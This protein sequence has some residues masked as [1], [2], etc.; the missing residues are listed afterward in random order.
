LSELINTEPLSNGRHPV[1]HAFETI[2]AIAPNPA[3]QENLGAANV[4]LPPQDLAEIKR[5][6][7]EIQIEGTTSS[8]LLWLI[9]P[10]LT[11]CRLVEAHPK[12]NAGWLSL[13]GFCGQSFQWGH[14]V[15][16]L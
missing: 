14:A 6:A 7:A 2:V 12:I 13:A 11:Q 1:H 15:G 8:C 9:P 10:I 5:A 16:C 3:P 4:E